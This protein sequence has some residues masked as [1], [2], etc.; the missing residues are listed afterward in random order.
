MKACHLDDVSFRLLFLSSQFLFFFFFSIHLC[1][2]AAAS[3]RC[4]LHAHI[5]VQPMSQQVEA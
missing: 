3:H 5:T 1:S 2:V 4:V